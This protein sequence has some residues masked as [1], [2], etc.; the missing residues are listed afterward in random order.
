M[1]F[2]FCLGLEPLVTPPAGDMAG[3]LTAAAKSVLVD[4]G[5]GADGEEL[6]PRDGKFS[7]FNSGA[8][9]MNIVKLKK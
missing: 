5:G 9:C 4:G 6:L 3:A 2:P 7:S 8:S 1:N